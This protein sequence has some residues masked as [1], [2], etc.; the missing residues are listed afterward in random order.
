MIEGFA[1]DQWAAHILTCPHQKP[2]G[3]QC[4]ITVKNMK[5]LSKG[6]KISSEAEAMVWFSQRQHINC[7]FPSCE[8][9]RNTGTLYPGDWCLFL[10]IKSHI[11]FSWWSFIFLSSIN[12]YKTYLNKISQ[13]PSHKVLDFFYL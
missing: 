4:F 11:T 5:K 9:H 2:R 10:C 12:I 3:K 13:Q 6:H 1:C 8:H 7:K